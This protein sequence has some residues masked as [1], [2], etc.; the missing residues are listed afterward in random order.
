MVGAHFPVFASK[1]W[2]SGSVIEF[3]GQ[4]SSDTMKAGMHK[5]AQTNHLSIA[6]ILKG[7]PDFII[8]GGEKNKQNLFEKAPNSSASGCLCNAIG[9]NRLNKWCILTHRISN[10]TLTVFYISK[11]TD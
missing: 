6:W 8:L 11:Y 4:V 2:T 9:F 7:S 3:I 5:L 1:F 10:K